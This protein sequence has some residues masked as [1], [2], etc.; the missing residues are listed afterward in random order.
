[1]QSRKISESNKSV[2]GESLSFLSPFRR[3]SFS[4]I[5]ILLTLFLLY[6]AQMG[7]FI[8]SIQRSVVLGAALPL[9]FLLYPNKLSKKNL[10]GDFIDVT[11]ALLG[12]ASCFY[13]V[14]FFEDILNRMGLPST[15]DIVCGVILLV[16]LVIAA[17]RVAG[18]ILPSLA[19]FFLA[20]CY[21][22]RWIPG[23][24]GHRGFSLTNIVRHMYLTTEGVFGVSL[25]VMSAYIYLFVFFGVVLSRCGVGQVFIDLALAAFGRQKGGPAKVAV[26]ASA[27]FGTI[28]G[29][30]MA[31]VVGTGNF[32]IPLMKSIGFKPHFAAAVEACAST[33]GQI[34]P[35]IMGAAAFI[36]AE[37]L[38][39]SY[40]T[41]VVAAIVPAVLYFVGVLSTVHIMAE[42]Q[43][44]ERLPS[45][46]VPDGWQILKRKG[47]LLLPLVVIIGFLV[48]GYSPTMAALWGIYASLLIP[49]FSRKTRYSFKDLL[50]MLIE[51]ARSNVQVL[52]I[53][54]IIGF[55]IGSA[56]LTGFG[57]KLAQGIVHLSGGILILGLVL[58]MVASLILGMGIPTTANY[59]MMAL[60]T[61][62]ALKA[63]GV[64]PINAHLFVFYFGIISDLTPPVAMTCLV[65]SGVAQSDFWKTAKSAFLMGIGA[66]IIPFFF[67]L[68]PDLLLNQ[69]YFDIVKTPFII[70]TALIGMVALISAVQNYLH[71]L[72]R[73]YERLLFLTSSLLLIS[74]QLHF[75]LAGVALAGTTYFF[76]RRRITKIQ[77]LESEILSQESSI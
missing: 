35:P 5:G 19:L 61:A 9:A 22:G 25:G 60:I 13:I 52:V 8:S 2:I 23:T 66:Y 46:K 53:A 62:P 51:G 21:F 20:Y 43:N 67:A 48:K 39:V 4:I 38:G 27:F 29:S 1:M 7:M 72:L 12:S 41:V 49:L 65:A 55:I 28:N 59:I 32:T 68:S 15:A 70:L 30:A 56:S 74:P 64:V 6:T 54:A 24:F 34:M 33:G 71:G 75:S 36:M 57:L 47:L 14:F 45:D 50:E 10:L 77:L 76:H 18:S 31:N 17:Y 3:I 26:I 44:L 37:F 63:L 16:V 69:E 40:L 58:T 42:K 11:L 73:Y